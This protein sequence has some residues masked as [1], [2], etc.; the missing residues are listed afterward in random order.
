VACFGVKFIREATFGSAYQPLTRLD[1]FA[2]PI[3]TGEDGIELVLT[4]GTLTA[5]TQ[6][7]QLRPG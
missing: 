3:N 6:A 7:L 5:T 2:S 1:V 4:F